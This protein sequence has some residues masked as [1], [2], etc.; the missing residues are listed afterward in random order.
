MSIAVCAPKHF[1]LKES[2]PLTK[3]LYANV[4]GE[5]SPSLHRN[6]SRLFD[7]SSLTENPA[8]FRQVIQFLGERYRSMGAD[9]PTHILGLESRGYL[10][11]APLALELGIPFVLA[12]ETKRFP[13]SFVRESPNA[14]ALVP[15][16]SIRNNS[17]SSDSRVLIVDDFIATGKTVI[18][19]LWLTDIVGAKVVEVVAACD[20]P[21]LNGVGAIHKAGDGTFKE[22][23]VLTLM[24]F[25]AT[26]EAIKAQLQILKPITARSQL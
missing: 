11:G 17:I 19:V 20:V 5:P 6:V 3:E 8:L 14:T 21:R 9:G 13:S 12:R 18:S 24:H 15:S 16:H 22:I 26:R 1:V 10:I 23:P 4:F 25:K 7:V 2:H